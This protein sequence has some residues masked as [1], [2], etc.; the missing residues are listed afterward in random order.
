MARNGP[1]TAEADTKAQ[2]ALKTP[3]PG[4]PGRT[5]W[6]RVPRGFKSG[7]DAVGEVVVLA[8]RM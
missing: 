3:L 5:P 6:V 7:A 1:A 4:D 2:R 8:P